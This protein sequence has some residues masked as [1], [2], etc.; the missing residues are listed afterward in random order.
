[1]CK[2]NDKYNN[3]EGNSPTQSLGKTIKIY[4]TKNEG[5][6]DIVEEF[7]REEDVFLALNT[8]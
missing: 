6:K 8:W 2:I 3:D 1:M 7:Y 4:N 5:L